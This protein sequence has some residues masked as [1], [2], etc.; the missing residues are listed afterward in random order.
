MQSVAD[1][2]PLTLKSEIDEFVIDRQARNLSPRTVQWY[3]HS[4]NIWAEYAIALG[5]HATQV[6]T[7]LRYVVSYY[8]LLNAATILAASTTFSAQSKRT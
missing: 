3:P 4:L 2:T 8:I 6:V 1:N 7:P 5:I